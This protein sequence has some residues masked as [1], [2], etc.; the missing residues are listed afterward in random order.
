VS[1]KVPVFFNY[2]LYYALCLSQVISKTIRRHYNEA[3]IKAYKKLFL[4]LE[5][6]CYDIIPDDHYRCL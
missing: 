3:V 1:L 5:C 2:S 4:V 6:Y